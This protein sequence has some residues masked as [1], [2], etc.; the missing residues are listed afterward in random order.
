MRISKH[1]AW[2]CA[3]GLLIAATP[4]FSAT[5]VFNYNQEYSGGQAPAG[6]AP[7][8]VSTLSTSPTTYT[9]GST[10]YNAVRLTI[11]LSNLQSGAFISETDFNID[12]T[13][14]PANLSFSF[15]SGNSHA[16]VAP[17]LATNSFKA[18]GDGYYDISFGFPTSSGNTFGSGTLAT[19]DIMA[20]NA[21]TAGALTPESF[22]FLS[23]PAGGH[24]PF[25][26]AAHVQNTTGACG[27]SGCTGSGWIAPSGYVVPLPAAAWLFGS[28]LLGLGVIARRKK[29]N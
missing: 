18:D 19:F 2:L 6:S 15:V 27:T 11:D 23:Q 25:Y 10:T 20:T 5:I 13:L 1:G 7:W 16:N 17:S 28:G 24:G 12:P 3:A 22:A 29:K 4:A 9:I 8:M 26:A 21:A 14:N